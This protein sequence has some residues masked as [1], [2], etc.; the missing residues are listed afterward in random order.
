MSTNNDSEKKFFDWHA[1][2]LG[3]IS[4]LREVTPSAGRRFTPFWAVSMS[5]L[6]GSSDNPEYTYYDLTIVNDDALEVL[7]R[8]EASINDKDCKVLIGVKVGDEYPEIYETTDKKTNKPV[9][10]VSMKARLINLNFIKIKHGGGQYQMVYQRPRDDQENQG[11]APNGQAGEPSQ[12]TPA[13]SPA[14]EFSTVEEVIDAIHEDAPT[15][16]LYRA[17][18]DFEAAKAELQQAGYRYREEFQGQT[19]VWVNPNL[20]KVE[21]I[22]EL[23]DDETAL[24]S[25]TKRDP[26]FDECYALLKGANPGYAFRK[27]YNGHENVW[28]RRD[29]LTQ[30]P[31]EGELLPNE[32]AA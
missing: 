24:I 12:E 8:Y 31:I 21:E 14:P 20:V 29:L 17:A 22:K 23:I 16:T 6:R 32:K 2:G 15:I 11:D 10:R 9:M 27:E 13:A 26:E 4:R 19:Y 5:A 30:Q 1:T 25:L 7:Q 3:Y 28:V 18:P